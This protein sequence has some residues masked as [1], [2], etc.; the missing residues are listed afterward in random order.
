MIGRAK[1]GAE[2]ELVLGDIFASERDAARWWTS[3]HELLG[4]DAPRAAVGTAEGLERVRQ[5]LVAI[6]AGGA[7]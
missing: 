2:I 6:R 5:L 7:V 4:G 3:P 1:D